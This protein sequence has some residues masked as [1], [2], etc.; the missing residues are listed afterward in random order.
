M[1]DSLELRAAN[2]G[3]LLQHK[4]LFLQVDGSLCTQAD[5]V[6]ICTRFQMRGQG[7]TRAH[8][9]APEVRD[10]TMDVCCNLQHS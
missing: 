2:L 5:V 1:P 3:I 6:K 10:V 7:P 9:K 8:I 4:L